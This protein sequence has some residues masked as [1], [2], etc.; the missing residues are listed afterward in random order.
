MSSPAKPIEFTVT[1]RGTAHRLSFLPDT[2]L[3]VL[4][5]HLEEL[6]SVPP[7][8]QKLL[9]KGK[10]AR[11]ADD[12]T[13]LDAGLRYGVKVQLLGSTVQEI[14]GLR[15]AED[16]HQRRERILRERAVKG[17]TRLRST[18]PSVPSM[19]AQYRFHSIE[20]LAHLPDPAAARAL[21]SRLASD[22]AILHVMQN[23]QFSVP[24]LTELA[25]HEHP[26]KLGINIS[27]MHII[28]L[29]LRTD[30]Y[31]GFRA[32]REIR[33][34]LCHELAHIVHKNHEVGFKELNSQLSREIVD[35]ERA[36]AE[37][38]HSLGDE[39]YTSS[40]YLE[41]EAQAYLASEGPHILGGSSEYPGDESRERRRRRVLQAAIIRLRKEEEE[42]ERQCGTTEP[43]T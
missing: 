40:S 20:P 25:P 35:F 9:Y 42:L 2:T 39:A 1:H 14:G 12:A 11:A 7:A 21:L 26:D 10:N 23:H 31:D 24:L 15:A 27:P 3:A 17:P 13:I 18:G 41:A 37:G 16:E 5:A 33:K 28:K 6:T 19:G 34:V 29:R 38:T 32:Y 36:A 8:H 4:Q 30:T 43:S 22:P